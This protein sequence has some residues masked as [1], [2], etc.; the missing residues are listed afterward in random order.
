[1]KAIEVRNIFR[2]AQRG[3]EA[4]E[5]LVENQNKDRAVEIQQENLSLKG[6]VS[7]EDMRQHLLETSA[8][9]DRVPAFFMPKDA[10]EIEFDTQAANGFAVIDATGIT[11]RLSPEYYPDYI[12]EI[13]GRDDIAPVAVTI[14]LASKPMAS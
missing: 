12:R 4:L 6:V 8:L 7:Q 10:A 13:L 3:V 5:R 1:M 9:K 11:I 2:L 14:G